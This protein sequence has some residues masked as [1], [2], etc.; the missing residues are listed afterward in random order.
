MRGERVSKVAQGLEKMGTAPADI[1]PAKPDTSKPAERPAEAQPKP[2]DAPEQKPAD[3]PEAKPA[4]EGVAAP[5]TAAPE[6]EKKKVNPWK[7]VDEWK[8]KYAELERKHVESTKNGLAENEKAEYLERLNKAEERIKSYE[9][10]LRYTNYSKSQEFKEKYQNRYDDRWKLAMGEL[11]ELTVPN[12]DGS[13]RAFEAKDLLGLMNLPLKEAYAKAQE[14]YGDLAGTV[15]NH[16]TELRRMHDEMNH[17]LEEA[18][19]KGGEREKQLAEQRTL[20]QKQIDSLIATSFKSVHDSSLKDPKNGRFF[21]QVEGDQEWNDALQ[22]GKE[23]A[24]A[25]LHNP[26]AP[27]LSTDQRKELSEKLAANFNRAAAFGPMKLL[28]T[29]L[30]KKVATL[31]KE[32]S[33]FKASSPAAATNAAPAPAPV[34][35]GGKRMDSM[36]A[37]LAKRG[38]A[39]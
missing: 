18:R 38:T 16:R 39:Q 29:R 30:E 33:G 31:E 9:D 24:A 3:S 6:G 27:G 12:P 2:A 35:A 19:T 36:F 21:N 1:A 26:A 25:F 10:D 34:A 20:E 11:N 5:S 17:A 37:D 4:E 23:L 14:L 8:A 15:I 13:E 22:R 7:V 32:L 28:V